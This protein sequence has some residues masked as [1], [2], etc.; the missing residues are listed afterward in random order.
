[1]QT[2]LEGLLRDEPLDK[3]RLAQLKLSFQV[4]LDTLNRLDGEIL[5]F[6]EEDELE[7]EIQTADT[8]KENVYSA[9]VK[10]EGSLKDTGPRADGTATPQTRDH[11]QT[12]QVDDLTI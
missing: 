8:F 6:V 11:H 9:M 2:Q 7:N 1:M 12:P 10:I 5:D 3:A 4:K